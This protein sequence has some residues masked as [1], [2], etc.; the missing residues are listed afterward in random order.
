[1]R[2]G[3]RTRRLT[4]LGLGITAVLAA[5]APDVRDGQAT[6][7]AQLVAPVVSAPELEQDRSPARPSPV[8]SAPELEQDRSPARP[9][10]VVSAPELEQDRSPARPFLAAARQLEPSIPVPLRASSPIAELVRPGPSALYDPAAAIAP[11]GPIPVSLTI[12]DIGLDAAPIRA[13]GVGPTGEMEIPGA[14]E[15]GWYRFGPRPGEAGSAV[16]AAHVAYDGRDGAFRHLTDLQAGATFTITFDD[17]SSRAYEVVGAA[18]HAKD[19]LPA[20]DL[21]R[22]HGTPGVALVTCGGAFDRSLNAYR[23]NVVVYAVPDR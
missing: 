19:E 13:V 4:G 9:S 22:R 21:F 1:M 5:C 3:R 17:G 23:D 6:P 20:A 12:G 18:Q 11:V 7:A 10:P 16:L 14:E 8:V 2:R 15:I